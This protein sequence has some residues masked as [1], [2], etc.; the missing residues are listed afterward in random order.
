VGAEAG[1]VTTIDLAKDVLAPVAAATTIDGDRRG[2]AGRLSR[3]VLSAAVSVGVVLVAWSAFLRVF[4]V[5]PFIGKGPHDV[6]QYLFTV[7]DAAANRSL[8]YSESITTLRDAFL[9]LA[10][11]TVAAVATAI[12]FNRFRTLQSTFM[13]I[14]MVLR[15]VPLVA[16]TPLIVLVFGRGLPAITVIAGIVTFFP[17]L[18]NVSLALQGTQREALDLLAAYGASPSMT[19]WKVQVPS[20]LPALFASLRIAAPL[21]LVGALLAEWLATG[22]G[23]G[24]QILASGALSNYNGLWSRVVVVTLCSVGLYKAIGGL[25]KLV[26]ARFSP[27]PAR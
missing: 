8:I 17:T 19:L 25:E 5:E 18:V 13:P 2:R 27:V 1:P 26:M 7:P 23:L 16:M 4:H 24:Y 20:S 6:W 11:G 14:A 10:F 21:A 12:A 3:G 9:G 15:S 22:Q